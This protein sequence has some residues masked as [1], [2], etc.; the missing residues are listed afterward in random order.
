MDNATR[1]ELD[2]NELQLD[3][4]LFRLIRISENAKKLSDEYKANHPHVP[5][6]VVS[7]LRN[8]IV[9]DYGSV[10][11][12][13]VYT[14]LKSDIPEYWSCLKENSQTPAAVCLAQLSRGFCTVIKQ[15]C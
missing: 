1:E 7:D 3:S 8:R 14:T 4:M 5:W 13:I 6:F 10:D 2:G 15:I 9:H 12:S 11:L